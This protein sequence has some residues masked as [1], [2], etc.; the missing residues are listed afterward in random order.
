MDGELFF[1]SCF[2]G[3]GLVG[4]LAWF[5]LWVLPKEKRRAKGFREAAKR[6]H[7]LYQ[8]YLETI[9]DD[10]VSQKFLL[11]TGQSPSSFVNIIQLKRNDF[12]VFIA[13]YTQTV[14]YEKDI[15]QTII[16]L[17]LPNI[18]LPC[19]AMVPH[20]KEKER[21]TMRF[22]TFVYEQT[23]QF[24]Q[25][26]RSIN[27]IEIAG[28]DLKA[29]EEYC[30]SVKKLF[31]SKIVDNIMAQKKWSV[32]GGGKMLLFYERE[33]LVSPSAL[34]EFV[35]QAIGDAVMFFHEN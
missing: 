13:D 31:S 25:G 28:Y 30:A 23:A 22:R 26:Y 20:K 16:V 11:L 9:P 18:D 12:E 3:G 21:F 27:N 32:E 34:D 4:L 5:F 1:F 10:L 8:P 6:I 15:V 2:F 17:K 14:V 24:F 33:Q 29:P 7:G 35:D 19:F